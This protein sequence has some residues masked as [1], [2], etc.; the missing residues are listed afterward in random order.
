MSS[1]FGLAVNRDV[2]VRWKAGDTGSEEMELVQPALD[3]GETVYF[4]DSKCRIVSCMVKD[5]GINKER[6][7]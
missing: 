2:Y 5:G 6:L 1:P 4:T 7:L 3:R